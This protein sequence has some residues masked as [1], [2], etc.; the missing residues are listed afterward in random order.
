MIPRAAWRSVGDV[1]SEPQDEF[2]LEVIKLLLQVAY[3]D[4]EVAPEEETLLV[5]HAVRAGFPEDQLLACLSGELP[6]PPPNL[7]LLKERRIEVL[8]AVKGM[9][10]SDS[11]VAPEEDAILAQISGLLR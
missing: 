2:A 6:L 1:P 5:R 4:D 8:R 9:L 10:E 3:A 7:G 11:H